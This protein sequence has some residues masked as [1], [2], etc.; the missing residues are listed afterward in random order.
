MLLPRIS[1]RRRRPRAFDEMRHPFLEIFRA[2]R[3]QHFF[4]RHRPGF[5]ERLEIGLED[6]PFDHADERG[7][8]VVTSSRAIDWTSAKSS[9]PAICAPCRA[10]PPRRRQP[11]APSREDRARSSARSGA[12]TSKTSHARQS[13]RVWRTPSSAWR[14]PPCSESRKTG[15]DRRRCRRPRR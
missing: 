13:A 6:L 10:V 12:A 4:V 15:R 9:P 8:E 11:S 1:S 7:D 14:R 3:C 2:E 5:G